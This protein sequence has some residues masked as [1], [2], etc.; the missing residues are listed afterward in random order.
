MSD[1]N[2]DQSGQCIDCGEEYNIPD[3]VDR[4]P[5][6][7]VDEFGLIEGMVALNQESDP[8]ER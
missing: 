8:E 2:P 7:F 5:D 6:C 3:G 4:C 1:R